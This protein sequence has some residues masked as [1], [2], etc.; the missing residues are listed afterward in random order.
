MRRQRLSLYTEALCGLISL[1]CGQL[2]TDTNLSDMYL[3]GLFWLY[4]CLSIVQYTLYVYTPNNAMYPLCRS[5]FIS[6]LCEV[7]ERFSGY[8]LELLMPVVN[9]KLIER[10]TRFCERESRIVA[11]CC[12]WTSTLKKQ[13]CLHRYPT[14]FSDS[15]YFFNTLSHIIYIRLVNAIYQYL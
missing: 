3:R 12:V 13:F 7:L 6:V 10:T 9:Q 5:V 11:E 4:S 14:G 2:W 1:W 15:A 8:C